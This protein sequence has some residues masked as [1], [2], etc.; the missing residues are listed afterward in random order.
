ML[1]FG[2]SRS[3]RVKKLK[4]FFSIS[5]IKMHYCM[6]FRLLKTFLDT[7]AGIGCFSQLFSNLNLVFSDNIQVYQSSECNS[8]AMIDALWV[9]CR[10]WCRPFI[11]L[12]E[13]SY[14]N[15]LLFSMSLLENC[16]SPALEFC[17]K[18]RNLYFEK[19]A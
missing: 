8:R 2:N 5:I 19:A 11:Y 6:C 18:K 12:H 9:Q 3:Q 1:P 4:I 17:Q 7:Q 15:Q 16:K 10:C 13:H 14:S